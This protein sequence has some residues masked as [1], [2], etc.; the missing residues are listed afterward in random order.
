MNAVAL[1]VADAISPLPVVAGPHAQTVAPIVARERMV[2]LGV[3]LA[4][5]HLCN[6]AVA[7]DEAPLEG[8]VVDA[9]NA[10]LQ[11]DIVRTEGIFQR[12]VLELDLLQRD[13]WVSA[14][15][16]TDVHDAVT[17]ALLGS[18]LPMLVITEGN[19]GIVT[20][21]HA[22]WRRQKWRHE[23]SF[24]DGKSHNDWVV[25]VFVGHPLILDL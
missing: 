4:V 9:V 22:A 14:V 25:T 7:E 5:P 11:C 13:C 24:W 16:L 1:W 15:I 21:S 18:Q 2:A 20:H 3:T 19:V 8:R 10:E 23:L 12:L 17:E 6:V